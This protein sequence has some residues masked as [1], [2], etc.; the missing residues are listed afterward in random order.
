MQDLRTI[1]MNP[2][3]VL[4]AMGL[5]G[6]T[7]A[8]LVWLPNYRLVGQIAT[9]AGIPFLQ[10]L[11]ILVSLLTSIS[12]NFSVVSAA[13]IIVIAALVGVNAALVFHLR[14]TRTVPFRAAGGSML[15]AFLGTFG[16]GCAACGM[17]AASWILS[18]VGISA[19][20]LSVL[21]FGGAEFGVAGVAAMTFSTYTLIRQ[22]SQPVVCTSS[23]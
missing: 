13:T 7:F 6:A 18:L 21:P 23:L 10:K 19:S 1:G 4:L 9:D 8:A 15:G 12:T 14:R 20:F 11:S 5:G 2:R 17:L 3:Y 22:L 16:V